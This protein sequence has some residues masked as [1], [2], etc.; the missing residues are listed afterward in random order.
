M[1]RT[2]AAD[3]EKVWAIEAPAASTLG[4]HSKGELLGG[5]ATAYRLSGDDEKAISY[6][7]RMTNE[8]PGTPYEQKAQK[9][10]ADLR[11]VPRDDHFCIGCH[12][13]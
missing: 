9:W 1:A 13:K 5:L 3:Y 8:L 4:T 11:A 2:A 7:K 10:L 12:V 6:L